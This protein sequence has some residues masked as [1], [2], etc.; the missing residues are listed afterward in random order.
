MRFFTYILLVSFFAFVVSVKVPSLRTAQSIQLVNQRSANQ[1]VSK[2]ESTNEPESNDQ[3]ASQLESTSLL[4]T[5][6]P[7]CHTSPITPALWNSFHSGT[8]CF[9]V[10]ASTANSQIASQLQQ[11]T[12]AVTKTPPSVAQ[13]MNNVGLQTQQLETSGNFLTFPN[14]ESV[15][16]DENDESDNGGGKGK[17]DQKK[18]TGLLTIP[19]TY[20]SSIKD[21]DIDCGVAGNDFKD[22]LKAYISAGWPRFTQY[23]YPLTDKKTQNTAKTVHFCFHTFSHASVKWVHLHTFLGQLPREEMPTDDLSSAFCTSTQSKGEFN[24]EKISAALLAKI[25]SVHEK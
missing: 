25:R 8:R 21:F 10:Y 15:L 12:G 16:Q 13:C 20:Q 4:K 6:Q 11:L 19:I 18:Y 7:A 23:F 1:P 14:P 2:P 9:T 17:Q 3:L 22:M 24:S 5:S